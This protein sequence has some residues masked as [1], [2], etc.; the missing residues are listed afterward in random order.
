MKTIITPHLLIKIKPAF[1]ELTVREIECLYYLGIGFTNS[2]VAL[3]FD[4]SINTVKKH[5]FNIMRKF[6]LHRISEMRV[7][8]HTRLI[9]LI[10]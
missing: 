4:I 6:N 7:V 10:L 5:S 9:T 8:F 1:P 3:F 2:D